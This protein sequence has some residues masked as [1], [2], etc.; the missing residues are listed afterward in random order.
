[1]S[2]ERG[3][4]IPIGESAA[5]SSIAMCLALLCQEARAAE[6]EAAV[7]QILYVRNHLTVETAWDPYMV[8]CLSVM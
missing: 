5:A 4:A 6:D 3:H 8:A 2:V 7:L 1:M